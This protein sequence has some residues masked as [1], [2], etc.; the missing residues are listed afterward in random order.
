MGDGYLNAKIMQVSASLGACMYFLGLGHL[1]S[2]LLEMYQVILQAK[3]DTINFGCQQG[4]LTVCFEE[5]LHVSMEFLHKAICL[6]VVNHSP[7]QIGSEEVREILPELRH[8]LGS[9]VKGTLEWSP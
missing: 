5:C 1:V 7:I 2:L 8:E 6:G 3:H 4:Q 9:S